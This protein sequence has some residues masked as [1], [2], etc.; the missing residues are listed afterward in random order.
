MKKLQLKRNKRA[1]VVVAHPDDETIWMGGT[2]LKFPD[3]HWT[4]FC[5]CRAS[6]PDRAPK[7]KRICKL[8]GARA[9]MT[10]LDDEDKLALKETIPV[11]EKFIL[12][13]VR[14]KKFDYIFTHGV[15]GE[16]GHPRHKGVHLAVRALVREGKISAREIYFFNYKKAGPGKRPS[17]EA[18]ADSDLLLPLSRA[19]FTRKKRMQAEI[20]GYAWNGIDNSLCTNPEAFKIHVTCNT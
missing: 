7:F 11:I 8:F 13:N 10:D 17:M 4:I 16:Y 15:N 6:D 14:D 19:V 20:H 1:L 3:V 9:I 12:A 18:K 2:I 5:L